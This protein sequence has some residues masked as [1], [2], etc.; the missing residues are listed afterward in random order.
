MQLCFVSVWYYSHFLQCSV[1][2]GFLW[3]KHFSNATTCVTKNTSYIDKTLTVL[4]TES[5]C[6][7]TEQHI[8][9]Y[10]T[11]KVNC[12]LLSKGHYVELKLSAFCVPLWMQCSPRIIQ[13]IF[14]FVYWHALYIKLLI[15]PMTVWGALIN[16]HRFAKNNAANLI[17][18]DNSTSIRDK[19]RLRSIRD[20]H[21][22]WERLD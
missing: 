6:F 18:M 10:A 11:V 12:F 14:F 5:I 8:K 4:L 21:Q 1:R 19:P 9:C 7:P 22:N 13:Y 17:N 20:G 2:V 16:W 3:T 15:K